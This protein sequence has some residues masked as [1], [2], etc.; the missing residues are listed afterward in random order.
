MNR[1]IEEISRTRTPVGAA[2]AVI[3]L[4]S[5]VSA[6]EGEFLYDMVKKS[7]KARKTLEVGCAEGL[8]TLHIC[9]ALKGR[10]GAQHYV[11]DPFQMSQ[12]HGAGV[13]ALERAGL[14]QY[15]TLIE[16]RSEV[17]LPKLLAQHENTFDLVFIDGWHTFDH[18]L[19]DCFYS[20]RLLAVGG[21][22]VID[23][24]DMA[25]VGKAV[26]YL[27]QYPCL[28]RIGDVT[29]YPQNALLRG[30]CHIARYTPI[31]LDHRH[32][33]PLT[34]RKLVRRPN[35]VALEKTCTDVR[36]WNWYA[37]F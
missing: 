24:C 18:T 6:H 25:S 7:P 23:D 27:S 12:W 30:L 20:L 34:L 22:L 35:M 11:I 31:S 29:D 2:G 1:V 28:R 5:E 8:S 32:K 15:A 26:A 33:L 36:G 17:A 14:R 19:I 21:L 16:E 37:P 9:D 13:R 10:E 3:P 4:N